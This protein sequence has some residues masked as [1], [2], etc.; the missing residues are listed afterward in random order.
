MVAGV[1]A[2]SV[3]VGGIGSAEAAKVRPPRTTTTTTTT[4]PP[5]PS[6][7][8]TSGTGMA[9]AAMPPRA[10]SSHTVLA[11]GDSLIGQAVWGLNNNPTLLPEATIIDEHRNATGLLSPIFSPAPLVGP[12]PSAPADVYVTYMLDKYPQADTVLFGWVGVCVYPCPYEYGSQAFYD[13]WWAMAKKISNLATARGKKVVWSITFPAPAAGS[14]A[15][16]THNQTVNDSLSWQSRQ[17]LAAYTRA[18]W[19]TALAAADGFLGHYVQ[20]LRY[21]WWP[22]NDYHQVHSDDLIHL[23]PYGSLRTAWWTAVALRTAWT[24]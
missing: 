3:V 5:P 7:A 11:I 2:L 16:Y 20:W 21:V 6:G 14:T 23:T 4:L 8:G 9:W 17:Q 13:A 15:P 24:R 10:A 1:A 18:D 12:Q 19:W 22:T